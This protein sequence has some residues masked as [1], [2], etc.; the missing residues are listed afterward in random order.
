MEITQ[1]NSSEGGFFLAE[2]DGKR[3]GYLSYEWASPSKFAIIHT[4]VEEAFQGRGVAKALLEAAVAFAR[5]NGLTIMP[6][7]PYAEKVFMRGSSY[8]D[9]KA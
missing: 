3:M 8:N 1:K 6:V 5:G 7:C 2:E 9:V 4:V